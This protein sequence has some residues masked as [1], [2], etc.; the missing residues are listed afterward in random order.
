M[1]SETM[2]V[3]EARIWVVRNPSGE[4]Q[5]VSTQDEYR[6]ARD[7]GWGSHG[8]AAWD[9]DGSMYSGWTITQEAHARATTAG[10]A[11]ETMTVQDAI[12]VVSDMLTNHLRTPDDIAI[13]TLLAHARATTAGT[14][15][16]LSYGYD[17]DGEDCSDAWYELTTMAASTRPDSDYITREWKLTFGQVRRYVEELRTRKAQKAT[18]AGG[19]RVT[20]AMVE[21][22]ARAEYARVFA[23]ATPI[24]YDGLDPSFRDSMLATS[25]CVLT[26]ALAASAR[27]A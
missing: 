24:T 16:D 11:S 6:A 20:D 27:G 15:A 22:G 1:A 2:T 14:G 17:D 7:A 10:T 21:A 19:G 25:R 9:A 23:E 5:G 18:G 8:F 12:A 13:E 3:A 26:A 4:V